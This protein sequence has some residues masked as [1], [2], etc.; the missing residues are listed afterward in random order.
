MTCD[1]IAALRECGRPVVGALNGTV[2]ARG[3]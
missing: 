2:A 1:L 3:P